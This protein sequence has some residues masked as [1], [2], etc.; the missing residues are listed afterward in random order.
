MISILL[1][2]SFGFGTPSTVFLEFMWVACRPDFYLVFFPLSLSLSWRTWSAVAGDGSGSSSIGGGDSTAWSFSLSLLY[3]G[4]WHRTRLVLVAAHSRV[5]GLS[6]VKDSRP[7][8]GLLSFCSMVSRSPG[9]SGTHWV[10]KDAVNFW[11]PCRSVLCNAWV[12]GMKA[13]TSCILS[14][15]ELHHQPQDLDF[16][17]R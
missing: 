3:P 13:R 9:W 1:W 17:G 6:S 8:S 4:Q 14:S 7:N 16:G 5:A 10:A 11:S 12:L 15:A 2:D